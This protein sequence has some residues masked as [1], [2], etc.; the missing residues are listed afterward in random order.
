[1]LLHLGVLTAGIAYVLYGWGLRTLHAFTA[2]SITLV[3]PLTAALAAFVVLGERL[4]AQGWMAGV[5]I[6]LALSYSVG[7]SNLVIRG[8]LHRQCLR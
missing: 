6:F 4:S 5:L 3:E 1:M 8:R 2:V 7:L